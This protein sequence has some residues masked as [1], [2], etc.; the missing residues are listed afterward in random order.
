[1]I[2]GCCRWNVVFRKYISVFSKWSKCSAD[3]GLRWARYNGLKASKFITFVFL[4]QYFCYKLLL[5][6]IWVGFLPTTVA[7]IQV[8]LLNYLWG[9]GLCCKP[10]CC[11][12]IWNVLANDLSAMI[13][14]CCSLCVMV[15]D[16][17]TLLGRLCWL[18]SRV[19]CMRII[20]GVT[21]SPPSSR[22][23]LLAASRASS[24]LS[25]SKPQ[26]GALDHSTDIN[27]LKKKIFWEVKQN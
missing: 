25:S 15:R 8:V 22:Q 18:S 24:F 1:M 26:G 13:H 27:G 23:C 12:E 3:L 2:S 10:H 11:L 19:W 4:L 17:Q 21:S 7:F 14:A 5:L 16:L 6:F 9:L 20:S